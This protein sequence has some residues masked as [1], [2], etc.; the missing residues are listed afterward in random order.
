MNSCK[1]SCLN[2]HGHLCFRPYIFDF[3]FI[4]W[5]GSKTISAF[6]GQVLC[7]PESAAFE[8]FLGLHNLDLTLVRDGL[9]Q[10]RSGF[11]RVMLALRMKSAA[12]WAISVSLSFIPTP[13]LSLNT[14]I[15][16]F[17]MAVSSSDNQILFLGVYCSSM[18]R[19]WLRFCYCFHLGLYVVFQELKV[20]VVLF[21]FVLFPF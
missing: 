19:S 7:Y 13:R 1:S 2:G 17:L 15:A 20:A 21:P 12:P 14:W 9:E 16:W 5:T 8:S 3:C 11:C 6:A 10:C 18:S 4:S